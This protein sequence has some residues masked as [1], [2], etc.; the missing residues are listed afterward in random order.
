MLDRYTIYVHVPVV[1]VLLDHYL[2]T[3]LTISTN[4]QKP[5]SKICRV[6]HAPFFSHN[7]LDNYRIQIQLVVAQAS[8]TLY[9]IQ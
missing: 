2:G 6:T 3:N 5:M 9:T 8:P 1:M 7:L 4:G